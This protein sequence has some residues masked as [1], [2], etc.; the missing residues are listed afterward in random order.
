[1]VSGFPFRHVFFFIFFF[2]FFSPRGPE[3]L[4]DCMCDWLHLVSENVNE[5][6]IFASLET[7]QEDKP[8]EKKNNL[9]EISVHLMCL[10]MRRAS[11]ISP[12]LI[13]SSTFCQKG[14]FLDYYSQSKMWLPTCV[15]NIYY[16]YVWK[17]KI[18][19]LKN[20]CWI[21]VRNDEVICQ[22]VTVAPLMNY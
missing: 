16:L 14:L 1:M 13:E 11:D 3:C 2:L 8:S 17:K 5:F 9:R 18:W 12:F 6:R 21:Y 20:N 10:R 4:C 7:T 19:R 15:L 22:K